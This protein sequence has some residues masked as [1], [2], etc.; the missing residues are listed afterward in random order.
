MGFPR[1]ARAEGTSAVP[2]EPHPALMGLLSHGRYGLG[3][4]CAPA[5]ALVLIMLA[6]RQ[7]QTQP[8]GAH[9][10]WGRRRI[11]H[12]ISGTVRC[13]DEDETFGMF[14]G[15]VEGQWLRGRVVGDER[16]R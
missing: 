1:L 16:E 13:S 5:A 4:L 9:R 14:D 12:G 2:A 8:S 10:L 3:T 6:P 11:D 7:T 15:Q